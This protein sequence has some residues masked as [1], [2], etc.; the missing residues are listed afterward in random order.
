[1]LIMVLYQ[2]NNILNHYFSPFIIGNN[3]YLPLY[4]LIKLLNRRLIINYNL[5]L[6]N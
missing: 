5:Q 6:I 3:Y 2:A 4:L 1:M